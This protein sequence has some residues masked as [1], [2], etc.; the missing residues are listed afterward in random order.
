MNYGQ[1][2]AELRKNN[3]M[4][5][6]DLGTKLNIT[7]QAVSKWENNLSEPDIDSIRKMCNLFGVSVDEFLEVKQSQQVAAT[8][9]DPPAP[10]KIISGYCEK[11]K[12]PVSPGEYTISHLYYNPENSP[13]KVIKSKA[14]H[15]YC[16][17]CHKTIVE[18]QEQEIK[19]SQERAFAEQKAKNLQNLKKGLLWGALACVISAIIFFYGYANNP[20]PANLISAI[21]LTL[22]SFTLTS[23]LFWGSFI[24]DFFFFFCRSFKAPFFFI[25]NLDLDGILWLLTVKLALWIIC[26]VL[27]VLFFL[28]GLFLSLLLSIICYPFILPQVIKGKITRIFD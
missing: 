10:S 28:I 5:Q 24:T 13:R 26:G 1:K 4:T 8:V 21:F 23:S 3:K 14:Q 12:K 27:S 25:F 17:S 11:C 20:Q 22:S 9:A 2:I 16:N 18:K 7:A 19:E 15:I 6:A